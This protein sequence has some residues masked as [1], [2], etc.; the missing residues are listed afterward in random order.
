MIACSGADNV[1]IDVQVSGTIRYQD[2]EYGRQ[3]FTGVEDYK[4]VRYAT[5][6][7][8]DGLVVIDS[9]ISDELGRYN[10][11]GSGVNLYLRVVAESYANADVLLSVHNY[12]KALYSVTRQI[13]IN[14]EN[15]IDVD[16]SHANPAVGAF[17]I[18]VVYINS[19]QFL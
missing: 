8:V 4:Y 9:T 10:L 1:S 7:L 18:L 13:K 15:E 2:K 11:I 14:G 5:V 16:I 12:N 6:E 3:G 17:N 19:T